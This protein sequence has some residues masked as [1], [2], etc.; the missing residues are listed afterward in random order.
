MDKLANVDYTDINNMDI[1]GLQDYINTAYVRGGQVTPEEQMRIMKAQQRIMQLQQERY[2]SSMQDPY[3]GA[4]SEAESMR[5]RMTD[6]YDLT[7]DQIKAQSS[8]EKR[9]NDIENQQIIAARQLADE[10]KKKTMDEF[11]NRGMANSTDAQLALSAIDK[12]L[13]ES[14]KAIDD[15][16]IAEMDKYREELKGVNVSR[17]QQHDAYIAQLRQKSA[18][19]QDNIAQ[20]INDYNMKTNATYQQK[21]DSL[22]ATS[23][24]LGAKMDTQYDEQDNAT[25]QNYAAVILDDAGNINTE[26]LKTVPDYL[27]PL[28]YKLAAESRGAKAKASKGYD[29]QAGNDKG[30]IWTINKDTGE[31][32]FIPQP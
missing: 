24:A 26:V 31:A 7:S 3:K 19:Y 9:L 27:I 17:L 14:I 13:T 16:R 32:Q 18:E 8:N 15:V 20:Q 1:G 30:G 25:A 10:E 28:V 12:S 11:A 4:L 2:V 22:F 29:V 23:S 5:K 6:P 21:I